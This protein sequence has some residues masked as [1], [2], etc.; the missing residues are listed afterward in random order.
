MG[1]AIEAL[2]SSEV[3]LPQ[4]RQRLNRAISEWQISAIR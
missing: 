4:M 2:H 3:Y 1:T